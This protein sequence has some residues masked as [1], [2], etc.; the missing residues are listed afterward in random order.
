MTQPSAHH[1]ADAACTIARH[2]DA[3][4]ASLETLSE[5]VSPILG[6]RDS[7]LS[8]LEGIRSVVA[9][10]IHEHNGLV[11]GA[12]LAVGPGTFAETAAW[13][14]AWHVRDNQLQLTRHSMNPSSVDFYDYTEAP[15]YRE[16]R[17]SGHAF[18]TS[19]YMDFGG[20]DTRIVT[21]AIPVSGHDDTLC[22]VAADLS[23]AALERILLSAIG[24]SSIEAA[25][26]TR[27]QRVVATNS[28]RL[29][30]QGRMQRVLDSAIEIETQRVDCGWRLAQPE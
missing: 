4:F 25:L 7:Q 9:S 14:Q 12:G 27:S 17:S 16:P 13:M 20:T 23:L 5:A 28:A 24:A 2:I 29:Y 1:L 6:S 8:D 15:W 10:T 3:I 30:L 19:P 18:L 21:A 11:T 22:V 26:I